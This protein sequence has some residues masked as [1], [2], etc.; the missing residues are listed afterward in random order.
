MV[1]EVVAPRTPRSV[2][3]LQVALDQIGKEAT[4]KAERLHITDP[5][6]IHELKRDPVSKLVALIKNEGTMTQEDIVSTVKA[7]WS[8]QE[9]T[10]V[11]N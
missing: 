3:E 11:G 9:E 7:W 2:E 6:Q 8:T 5:R 1:V 10:P 4:E